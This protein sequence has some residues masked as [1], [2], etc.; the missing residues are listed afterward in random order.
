MQDSIEK[1]WSGLYNL[2][3]GETCLVIGN[4]KSLAEETNYFLSSY[5]S[6]GTNRIYL[7]DGFVPNYYVCINELVARQYKEDIECLD[8]VKFVTDKV[9]IGGLV[10]QIP[11]HSGYL[12]APSKEPGKIIYEG[13]T[14]TYV[15]LQLAYW[16]GFST[17]LLVGVD[18]SYKFAGAPHQE[19]VAA[20]ADPNHFDPGYFSDNKTWNA[21]DLEGSEKAYRIAKRVFEQDGRAIIN[22]TKGSA[23]DVFEKDEDYGEP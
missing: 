8:T 16:M 12:M 14:V 22:I 2:H 20:G 21:P 23:L 4:G 17:V 5:P 18:H 6:F 11:L 1:A 13:N 15:C 10:R 7:K 3:K 19:L 9:E